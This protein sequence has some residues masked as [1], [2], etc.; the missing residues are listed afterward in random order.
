MK[1]ILLLI[2]FGLLGQLTAFDKDFKNIRIFIGKYC[3]DCHGKK[4]VKGKVDFSFL[5][6]PKKIVENYQIL[7]K[8]VQLVQ[9]GEMPPED[10]LSPGKKA[11]TIFA[12]STHLLLNK[13]A[14]KTISS[15]KVKPKK[16]SAI[17]LKNSYK[18]LLGY[19]LRIAIRESVETQSESSMV[20][21]LHPLD[22]PGKSGFT[23]DS[24]SMSMSPAH[25]NATFQI[26]DI[27]IDSLFSAA[28]RKYLE[29]YSGKISSKLTSKHLGTLFTRFYQKAFRTNDVAD[30]A[31]RSIAHIKKSKLPLED[32][33]KRELKSILISPKFLYLGYNNQ[34]DNIASKLSYFLWNSPPDQELLKLANQG[35]LSQPKILTRQMNRMLQDPRFELFI[36]NFTS[37]WLDLKEIMHGKADYQMLLTLYQQPQKFIDYLIKENRPVEEL[38]DTKVSFINSYLRPYYEEKDVTQFP[39]KHKQQKQPLVKVEIQN[40]S[41]RG[42]LLTMP[43][44]LKMYGQSPILRG[45]WVLERILGDHLG[46]PPEDVPPL[47]K[48]KKGEK[49]TP[50]QLFERHKNNKS[51]AVCHDR[52]DPLGFGLEEYNA[53]GLFKPQGM[54][55][56]GKTPNGKSFKTFAE[57]KKIIAKDYKKDI[58]INLL[59]RF[60][61]YSN[62]AKIE[63]TDEKIIQQMYG[64]VSNKT[65]FKD[66]LQTVITDPS[67]LAK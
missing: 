27:A 52:I 63:L 18:D 50:R 46:E 1:Y 34:M 49:F 5:K 26:A 45:V 64:K 47:K 48:P 14:S 33:I 32:S 6:D 58:T 53:S 38:I 13:L 25:L 42:G 8:S 39:R 28:N 12:N 16:L 35:V 43:G 36:E 3:Y 19:E 41:Y 20:L 54:D 61:A 56:S 24:H 29:G 2:N 60:Y 15:V 4:K 21:K 67:F 9:E 30:D 59:K 57:L 66:L 7:K 23:R 55:A 40:T 10:E 44:F 37:E 22:P 65:N 62:A 11:K 51:C 17:E 31:A